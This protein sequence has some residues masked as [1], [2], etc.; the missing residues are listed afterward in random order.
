MKPERTAMKNSTDGI[1]IQ[2][3]I[4]PNIFGTIK[5][6]GIKRINDLGRHLDRHNDYLVKLGSNLSKTVGSY[7]SAYSEFGKVNKDIIK[8]TSKGKPID[9]KRIERPSLEE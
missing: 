2:I 7:N 4:P 6:A 8:I 5:A 1:T 3:P 9:I